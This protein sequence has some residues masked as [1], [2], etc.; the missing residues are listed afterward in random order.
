MIESINRNGDLESKA[1]FSSYLSSFYT[2]DSWFQSIPKEDKYLRFEDVRKTAIRIKSLRIILSFA[3]LI[4]LLGATIL[5][6]IYA[7]NGF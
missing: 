2:I 1:K 6:M 5:L 7:P 4:M 3:G